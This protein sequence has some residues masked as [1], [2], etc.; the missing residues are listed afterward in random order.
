MKYVIMLLTLSSCATSFRD[1]R[2]AEVI[3]C[4]KEMLEY[5]P[6]ANAAFNICNTVQKEY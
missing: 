6:D 2:K 1:R 3:G 4:T 5:T